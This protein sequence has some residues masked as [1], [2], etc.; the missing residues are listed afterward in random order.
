MHF[1]N[2]AALAPGDMTAWISFGWR[3]CAEIRAHRWEAA[4][5]AYDSALKLTPDN[6]APNIGKATCL[7]HLGRHDEAAKFMALGRKLEPET[8]LALW[9]LRYGRSHAGSAVYP[10]FLDHLRALWAGSE[11]PA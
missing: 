5:G 11:P 4:L 3:G 2:E 6:A 7:R 8:P 9:E 1:D 10:V